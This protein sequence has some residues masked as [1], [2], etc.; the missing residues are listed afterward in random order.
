MNREDF[1]KRAG[2]G[3]GAVA[4]LPL[5][6]TAPKALTDPVISSEYIRVQAGNTFYY[7]PVYN[8]GM[9][10]ALGSSKSIEF[11]DLDY[12]DEDWQDE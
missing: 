11:D 1:L 9:P 10:P 4:M 7:L 8:S 12:E 3:L 5:P 6:F 2:F